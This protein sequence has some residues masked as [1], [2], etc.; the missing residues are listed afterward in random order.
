M[1]LAALVVVCL[2]LI[3]AG[4]G[5]SGGSSGGPVGALGEG[6]SKIAKPVRDLIR[7]FG[8]TAEAKGEVED[9]R[10]EAAE[11]RAENGALRTQRSRLPKI[12]R[13]I[14]LDDR[15]GLRISQMAPVT[16][17]VVG[18]SPTAWA[19]TIRI[20]K[21]AVD[22]IEEEQP[23]VGADGVGAGLVGFVTTVRQTSA[24]VTLLPTPGQSIGAKLQGRGSLLTVRGAGAGTSTDLELDFAPSSVVIRER[25]LVV[26]AGTAADPDA[27]ESKAPPGIP[28]G[29][30]YDVSK[31]GED[32]QVGHLRPLVDLRAL[33]AVQ[34]LTERVDGNRAAPR[35]QR[36]TTTTPR[37]GTGST[38][39]A[40]GSA[41]D[42]STAPSTSTTTQPATGAG[43]TSGAG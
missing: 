21:G 2:V 16:A 36:R 40:T 4:F 18:Q 13:L 30:I 22:G 27:P 41:G 11:L 39:G 8:D 25:A 15:A 5:A 1:I 37:T 35:P 12:A 23:V 33:E 28:I 19:S 29:R 9:L 24:V 42:A 7:W 17:S 34:V 3:T 43:A 31:P 14:E 38:S 32:G 20:D 26:T 10:E 6:A